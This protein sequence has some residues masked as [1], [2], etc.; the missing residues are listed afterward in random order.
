MKSLALTTDQISAGVLVADDTGP[1][2]YT[3]PAVIVIVF[4]WL[5][6]VSARLVGDTAQAIGLLWQLVVANL[7]HHLDIFLMGCEALLLPFTMGYNGQV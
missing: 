3:L 1:R 6:G 7:A 2:F 5:L 4:I